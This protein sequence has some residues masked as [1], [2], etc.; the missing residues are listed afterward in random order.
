MIESQLPES[1]PLEAGEPSGPVHIIALPFKVDFQ[2]G[3]IPFDA[4]R[5]QHGGAS[6]F[7]LSQ[8]DES[9]QFTQRP[10][11]DARD[12]SDSSMLQKGPP[13]DDAPG[14]SW[15]SIGQS[16]DFLQAGQRSGRRADRGRPDIPPC[17]PVRTRILPCSS[18]R[19]GPS[20]LGP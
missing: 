10:R 5:S 14:K 3:K 7:N 20:P 17:H 4:F 9:P 12:Y 15:G 2:D 11:S 8:G 18:V 13:G 16:L 6:C 19:R 1:P